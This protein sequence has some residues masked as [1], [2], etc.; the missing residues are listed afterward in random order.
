M[1]AITPKEFPPI[2]TAR[3][4]KNPALCQWFLKCQ[5]RATMTRSHPTL[6]DVDLCTTCADWMDQK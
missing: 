2:I 1:S 5:N 6:G 3:F 4:K